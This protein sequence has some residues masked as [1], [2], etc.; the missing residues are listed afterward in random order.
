MNKNE[1]CGHIVSI[2]GPV[3]EIEFDIETIELL[4]NI[5]DVIEVS[6]PDFSTK[7]EVLAHIGNKTIKAL[8]LG[9]TFMLGKGM[10]VVSKGEQL[11]VPVN[12]PGRIF[13][14]IGETID[15]GGEDISAATHS[16]SSNGKGEV[17]IIRE[18]IIKDPPHFTEVVY[19]N[20]LLH[21]YIKVIDLVCPVPKGGKVGFFGSAGV[22]KTVFIKELINNFIE[23][24]KSQNIFAGVGERI[25][26][27]AEL[28]EEFLD[29]DRIN[30]SSEGKVSIMDNV[31][32]IFGQMNE[33]PGIRFRTPHSAVTIAEYL[34]DKGTPSNP[35]NIVLFIDNIF[36]FVQAGSEVSAL[37]GRIPSSV[38]YQPT[39]EMEIGDLQE[40]ICS[41]KNG[42]ITSIQAVYVPADDLTD[43]APAAIFSH[44]DS[45]IV[46][47]REIAEKNIYPAVDILDSTS[48]LIN[49]I[50]DDYAKGLFDDNPETAEKF[51]DYQT[52]KSLIIAQPAI[53]K[54]VKEVL[55]TNKRLEKTINL[56]GKSS[57]NQ[58]QLDTHERALRLQAFFTQPFSVSESF[59][60]LK[61]VYVPLWETL[62]GCLVLLYN[63]NCLKL[64]ISTYD[65]IGNIRNDFAEK[66]RKNERVQELV[67][68]IDTDRVSLIHKY[69]EMLDD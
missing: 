38:G 37:L 67:K 1:I 68:E 59:T 58:E 30:K 22:G 52:F 44:L 55:H 35:A 33:P 21:S 2:R 54:K 41:T 12:V 16:F 43:P 48:N 3:C 61:G 69:L 15:K 17:K 60:G 56:L 64:P 23:K 47:K 27:G 10:K 24:Y 39:L 65:Y 13:N 9:S 46:L 57:L 20:Q 26:E 31:Y 51:A 36:R 62:Y 6:E 42:N 53:L 45:K 40:R 49:K 25:R 4:P 11:K 32:F 63:E 5:Y 14:T 19:S 8:A 34:R 18:S 50:D 66:H 7:L 29:L 28:W